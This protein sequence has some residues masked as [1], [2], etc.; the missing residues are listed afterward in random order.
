MRRYVLTG[1]PGSGKTSI[2]SGLAR[3]GYTIVS[4]AATEVIA[5]RQAAGEM[6][7]WTQAS[8]IDDIVGLQH[9]RQRNAHAA[10][11]SVQVFD[12]SPVCTYALA[13]YLGMPISMALS[14]ELERIDADRIYEPQVLFVR[15]LSF[16]EPTRA[17]RITHQDALEFE[18][19]HERSYS[20]FGYE[21]I[22]I[23]ADRLE[24]R[25]QAVQEVISR[26]TSQ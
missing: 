16:C 25:I 19:I 22:D 23:P 24:L 20:R 13:I 2:L 15:S 17:R 12:R 6:E 7:P 5:R 9:Q 8:F 10:A 26:L 21:L 11:G 1:T 14:A 18:R 4:E 3:L